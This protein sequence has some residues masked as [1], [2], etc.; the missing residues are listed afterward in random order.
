MV[1]II[2]KLVQKNSNDR[3]LGAIEVIHDLAQ[4]V[5]EEGLARCQPTT[6]KILAP[7]A[8]FVMAQRGIMV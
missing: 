2:N 3:Y 8:A 5:D 7:Y 1:H 6:V 4:F